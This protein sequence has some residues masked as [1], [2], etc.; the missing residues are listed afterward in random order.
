[1]LTVGAVQFR[2]KFPGSAEDVGALLGYGHQA[3]TSW[4][5]GKRRPGVDGRRAIQNAGGPDPEAWNTPYQKPDPVEST[6]EVDTDKVIS[7]AQGLYDSISQTQ[8]LINASDDPRERLKMTSESARILASLGKITGAS[9]TNERQ[10][11]NSPPWKDL[12]ARVLD[13][14][15]NDPATLALIITALDPAE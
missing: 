6:D 8:V 2:D 12:A 15:A 14:A 4:R 13:A 7:A 5:T 3:V 11:I 10:I 9:L 1:M